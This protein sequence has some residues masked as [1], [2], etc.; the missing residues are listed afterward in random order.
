MSIRNMQQVNKSQQNAK[1]YIW[2]I[3]KSFDIVCEFYYAVDYHMER[4]LQ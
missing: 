2:G 3:R 1:I 4:F